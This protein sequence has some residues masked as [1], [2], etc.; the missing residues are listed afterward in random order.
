MT[1][2]SGWRT[3]DAGLR[4]CVVVAPDKFKGTLTAAQAAAAMEAG[5]HEVFPEASVV[6]MPLADGGEGT[7]DVA[8]AAGATEFRS[9]VQGPV[10]ERVMA[11]WA[12]LGAGSAAPI[13]VIESAEAGGLHLVDPSPL[14]AQ[15]AHS[16]GVG[17]L[18]QRAMDAGAR[19][20]VVGLGGS[21][22]TDGGSGALRALGLKVLDASGGEVPLGGS[23]L[24]KAASLDTT[25]LDPRLQTV[26]VRLAVDVES[27][28]YGQDGA[29]YLFAPQKGASPAV[30]ENLD[31][32]LRI[33]A[34]L[35][36]VAAPAGAQPGLGFLRSGSGA[37]GGFPAGFL[38]L[39]PATVERGFDLV[40]ELVGLE[41]ALDQA[42]LLVVG[43]GS[44]DMQST[45]G[46]APLSATALAAARD[47]PT[48]AVAG[49]LSL[50]REELAISGVQVAVAL[51]EV[52]PSI[53][54]ARAEASRYV[55]M[56]VA[57]GISQL[58]ITDVPS[59]AK[60][61]AQ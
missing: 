45:Q 38:A 11:R 18:I 47:I 61:L 23:G 31:A 29:A 16:F 7:L 46:K 27:P 8:L 22:M 15:R 12:L 51:T 53:V 5:V 48:L 49:L 55:Q 2:T 17:E 60:V 40:S 6:R 34:G 36:A 26:R 4:P 14:S 41:R 9:S 44:L 10:G 59:H 54:A 33:W 30:V 3:G 42:D 32:A 50:S 19:E 57:E 52:A 1:G 39:T 43:E 28:L 13:A 25:A 35:L 58:R 24:A 37:A 20:I 56:A 21:A